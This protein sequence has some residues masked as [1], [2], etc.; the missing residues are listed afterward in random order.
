M[1]L[2]KNSWN[3]IHSNFFFHKLRNFHLYFCHE[4]S[5]NSQS[6]F[7]KVR[8]GIVIFDLFNWIFM[9]FKIET[10]INALRTRSPNFVLRT[11][12]NTSTRPLNF[13]HPFKV[14]FKVIAAPYTGSIN[15]YACKNAREAS[16]CLKR[17]RL[18]TCGVFYAQKG[19]G[20]L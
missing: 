17:K 11:D 1:I 14:F 18:K 13:I 2:T 19:I 10:K 16:V 6:L 7:T 8:E 3:S 9:R 5:W 15:E 20:N 12:I 4:L